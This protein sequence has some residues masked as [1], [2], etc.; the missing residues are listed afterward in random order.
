[1]AKQCNAEAVGL[2][3]ILKEQTDLVPEP[4]DDV[5]ARIFQ[6]LRA[7]GTAAIGPLTPQ[8]LRC[9]HSSSVPL[10]SRAPGPYA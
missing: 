6:E 9:S 3:H 5:L 2:V 1:M 8:Q 7:C 4:V 10:Q